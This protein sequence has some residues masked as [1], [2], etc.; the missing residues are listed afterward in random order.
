MAR[1]TLERPGAC[2]LV[3][4]HGRPRS[5]GLGVPLGGAADRAA[6]ALGNAL[7]GN[8]PEAAALEFALA[9]PTLHADADLACV[10]FGAP[11]E[12]FS[13]RQ[14]LTTGKTFTLRAGETLTI[15][16][17]RYGMRAYFCVRG[18]LQVPLVLDS[19]S[20]LEPLAA[21]VVL[22]CAAGRIHRRSI[23]ADDLL[24]SWPDAERTVRVLDGPQADWFLMN[25]FLAPARFEVT[26]ASNRMGLRL[27][28]RALTVPDREMTSEPVCPG[29]AQVTRDGR[30][31]ILGVDGQ[32]IGGYPKIAQIAAVDL[33]LLGQL[34]PGEAVV[35]LRITLEEARQ[36]HRQR[37]RLLGD[38]I[39]RLRL[40]EGLIGG[41]LTAER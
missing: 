29:A 25:E 38:W 14:N 5:R 21:G 22:E 24:P 15:A 27:S 13:D 33:D 10:V 4:D 20:S 3:V 17:T 1:L 8:P 26:P 11:F 7:V 9:G 37:Q 28:G 16:G 2:T 36:L 35:F 19:R 31:I 34:R 12:L 18:G 39:A 40:A 30:C 41:S 6:L 23:S 32:T